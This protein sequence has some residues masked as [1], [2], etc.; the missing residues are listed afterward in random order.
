MSSSY[1]KDF[2]SFVTDSFTSIFQYIQ[3]FWV[4]FFTSNT[5]QKVHFVYL[6]EGETESEDIT[7]EY[8]KDG[9]GA[10]GILKEKSQDVT[11][12]FFH[13]EYTYNSKTYMYLT[14]DPKHVFP[15][16]RV[17]TSFRLPI[18]EAFVLDTDGAPVYNVTDV[19]KMYEGPRVDFHGEDLFL[20]D[21]NLEGG[22]TLRLVN[23]L[24]EVR[25]YSLLE[26]SINHRTIWSPSKT[27]ALPDLQHC[28]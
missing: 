21:L 12:F 9:G 19:L 1:E 10:A 27:S 28:T 24:G 20:R 6:K 8:K 25:E 5:I 18:Q 3:F 7:Y 13:I 23:V 15:P 16:P 17:E 14:R 22:E 4:Y 26:D 2:V 11:D